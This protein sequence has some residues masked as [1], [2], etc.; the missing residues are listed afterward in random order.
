VADE[1]LTS[2]DGDVLDITLNRPEVYNAI[3]RAMHICSKAG[4]G[5][6]ATVIS[7]LKPEVKRQQ[8]TAI[9]GRPWRVILP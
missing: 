8:F 9:L 4:R 1:V 5:Y 2:R 3:N 7:T 6:F